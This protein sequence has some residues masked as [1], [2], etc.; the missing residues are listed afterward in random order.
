MEPEGDGDSNYYKCAWNNV[1]ELGKGTGRLRNQRI[2][3][4][5]HY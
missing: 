2:I 5:H 1:Q 3:G 4:D